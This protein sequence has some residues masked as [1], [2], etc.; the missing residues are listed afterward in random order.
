M[1]CQHYKGALIEA[2]ASG[3]EPQG[4]LR[5]HLD[6]CLDCRAAFQHEQSL[7]AS[8]VAGL[9]A[10]AT[11][12]VLA[13]LLPRARACRNEQA[14]GRRLCVPN[15]LVLASAAVI[16]VAFF[17]T[18]AVGRPTAVGPPVESARK[19]VVPALVTA[20]PQNHRPIVDPQVRK[21]VV[22]KHQLVIAK[23][24]PVRERPVAG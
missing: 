23:N 22:S 19:L 9:R 10:P 5:A 11:T 21:N 2:A 20:A 7:L 16:V 14:A 8:K 24:H 15:W 1:P 18:S 12:V 6:V 17:T 4:E 3:A 13:H